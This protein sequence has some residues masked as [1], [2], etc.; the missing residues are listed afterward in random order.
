MQGCIKF[1]SPSPPLGR[2]SRKKIK[3]GRRE[4]EAREEGKEMEGEGSAR[5]KRRER[6]LKEKRIGR[7]GEGKREE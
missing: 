3:W 7:G 4:G 2:I 5:G 1:P 6:E